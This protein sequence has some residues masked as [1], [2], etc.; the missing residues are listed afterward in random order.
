M[1]TL[2]VPCDANTFIE[3]EAELKVKHKGVWVD[4]RNH[5]PLKDKE[6]YISYLRKTWGTMT[7]GTN[8]LPCFSKWGIGV[9]IQ[10]GHC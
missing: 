2:C 5:S 9:H 6:Q 1:A 4:R 10:T 7:L 8:Q 3:I